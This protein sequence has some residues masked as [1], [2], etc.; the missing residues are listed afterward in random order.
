MFFTDIFRSPGNHGWSDHA[1]VIMKIIDTNPDLVSKE[2]FLWVQTGKK[3]THTCKARTSEKHPC[4]DSNSR[5][6]RTCTGV[7][8]VTLSRKAGPSLVFPLSDAI[9]LRRFSLVFTDYL[10]WI[11][12][13][14]LHSL[15]LVIIRQYWD[16]SFQKVLPNF[17]ADCSQLLVCGT[18]HSPWQGGHAVHVCELILYLFPLM[19]RTLYVF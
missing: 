13:L 9:F 2:S 11:P 4:P 17:F 3:H 15:T 14:P 10:V 6:Y 18:L 19:W 1:E 8:G 7:I 12:F 16:H 5:F